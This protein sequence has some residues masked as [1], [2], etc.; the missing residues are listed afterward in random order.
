VILDP[1][2]FEPEHRPAEVKRVRHANVL[3]PDG[4]TIRDCLALVTRHR[5]YVV[6]PGRDRGEGVMRFVAEHDQATAAITQ[7]R[8]L[9]TSPLPIPLTDDAGEVKV[10]KG[11]GCGCGGWTLNTYRLPGSSVA[12]SGT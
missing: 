4:T 10:W 2:A 8:L 5:V 6:T 1:K 12:R 7:P 3:L 11:E 9:S